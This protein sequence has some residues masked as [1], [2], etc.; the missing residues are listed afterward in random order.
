M[1]YQLRPLPN[2]ITLF[3][4][5]RQSQTLANEMG[6]F[7]QDRWT[8]KRLTLTGGLRYDY[9]RSSFPDQTRRTRAE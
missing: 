1:Q 6:L 5:P 7:A 4:D 3:V 8:V 2:S 9:Y